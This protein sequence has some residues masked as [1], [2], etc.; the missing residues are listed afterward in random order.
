M[1]NR[2]KKEAFKSENAPQ[3]IGPYSAGIKT[4]NYVFTSGQIGIN[5]TTGNIVQ[6]GI[7]A[8]TRQVLKNIA[9]LLEAAGTGLDQ[10]VKTTVFLQNMS[11]FAA[12]NAV[13]AEYFTAEP[14]ARST[15][16]VAGLPKGALVEIETVTLLP[17]EPHQEG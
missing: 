2:W 16:A 8:E 15:V 17:G 5:P 1:S 7:E 4:G 6:G 14:P 12:M 3:P 13:Y 9:A 11:D 10:V